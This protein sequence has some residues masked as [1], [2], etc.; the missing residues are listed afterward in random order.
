MTRIPLGEKAEFAFVREC[1]VSRGLM[2]PFAESGGIC[3]IRD[4][5]EGS[6]GASGWKCDVAFGPTEEDAGAGA[7]ENGDGVD[8]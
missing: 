8:G 4:D 5:K 1:E 2:F 3:D 6:V 7:G